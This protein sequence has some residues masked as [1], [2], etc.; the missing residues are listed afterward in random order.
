[1]DCNNPPVEGNALKNIDL[2]GVAKLPSVRNFGTE[3]AQESRANEAVGQPARTTNGDKACARIRN[4][5]QREK[6]PDAVN[7][8]RTGTST[9][10]IPGGNESDSA[11][12]GNFSTTVIT[13]EKLP[14]KLAAN[15][16]GLAKAKLTEKKKKNT[17][18]LHLQN[19]S[20]ETKLLSDIATT[21]SKSDRQSIYKQCEELLLKILDK[22]HVLSMEEILQIIQDWKPKQE[23][24]CLYVR[25]ARKLPANFHLDCISTLL[26]ISKQCG[27]TPVNFLT[28]TKCLQVTPS[29][30][31]YGFTFMFK[32]V[33]N[34]TIDG[35]ALDRKFVGLSL[36]LTLLEHSVSNSCGV[37]SR[38]GMRSRAPREP[39]TKQLDLGGASNLPFKT[40]PSNEFHKKTSLI[41]RLW[42]AV[43]HRWMA[44]HLVEQLFVC[45]DN[46][47]ENDAIL[48][49][50]FMMHASCGKSRY[51][52]LDPMVGIC[53][54][55]ITRDDVEANRGRLNELWKNPSNFLT[56]GNQCL[57]RDNKERKVRILLETFAEMKRQFTRTSSYGRAIDLE[58]RWLMLR[59][60]IFSFW[61]KRECNTPIRSQVEYGLASSPVAVARAKSQPTAAKPGTCI[62]HGA[63]NT[64]QM[65]ILITDS[66][67]IPDP[68]CKRR[69]LNYASNG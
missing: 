48:V 65:P 60:Y 43:N 47:C 44:F 35:D 41:N 10:K 15:E 24:L 6:N 62:K 1:M 27:Y 9:K 54:R 20:V 14:C 53:F 49:Y 13:N 36:T 50:S 30:G 25:I 59:A 42:L 29:G 52:F 58:R 17:A 68:I 67:A 3:T 45:K 5:N 40:M 16:T 2:P 7:E 34:R 64:T 63:S 8:I 55:F 39:V 51:Q 31:R 66:S 18:S 4:N 33:S 11:A 28:K 22:D 38:D 37:I 46:L 12:S 19:E 61:L 56:F 57:Q 32:T 69:R 23:I 21:I 26:C